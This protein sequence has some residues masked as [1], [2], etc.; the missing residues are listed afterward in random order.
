MK[1]SA[2]AGLALFASSPSAS[3]ATRA[4]SRSRARDVSP[5][6]FFPFSRASSPRCALV[7]VVRALSP[8]PR[9]LFTQHRVDDILRKRLE[10]AVLFILP[11]PPTSSPLLPPHPLARLHRPSLVSAAARFR[12]SAFAVSFTLARA[13]RCS[14][15]RV[16]R[17]LVRRLPRPP[18]AARRRPSPTR[19]PSR[20]VVA[21]TARARP[22]RRRRRL[23]ASI[24]APSPAASTRPAR[25]GAERVDVERH[26]WAPRASPSATLAR[27]R[28]LERAAGTDQDRARSPRGGNTR[29]CRASWRTRREARTFGAAV[30]PRHGHA[31]DGD[32]DGVVPGARGAR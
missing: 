29:A 14:L 31:S 11:P 5:L 21:R 16:A 15:A 26:A 4:S 18:R 10:P 7:R 13:S 9:R 30:Q 22:P 2:D 27:A 32:G 19:A 23:A 25:R 3:N 8:S 28:A 24:D 12:F 20:A 6:L 17:S 1:S